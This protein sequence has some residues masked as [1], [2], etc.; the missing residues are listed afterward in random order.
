MSE[1]KTIYE[2]G[3]HY[4]PIE[5]TALDAETQKMIQ[6]YLGGYGEKTLG[7]LTK[8]KNKYIQKGYAENEIVLSVLEKINITKNDMKQVTYAYVTTAHSHD[9]EYVGSN[10]YTYTSQSYTK[11]Q[12]ELGAKIKEKIDAYLA[13]QA[14]KAEKEELESLRKEV[15]ELREKVQELQGN[16]DEE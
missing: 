11:T 8:L 15:V 6:E 2:N 7:E 10:D 16:P 9:Y 3:E 4:N 12:N 14:A 13:A 5:Y 1:I